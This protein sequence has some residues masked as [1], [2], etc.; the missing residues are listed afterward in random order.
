LSILVKRV[1]RDTAPDLKT[2][3]DGAVVLDAYAF[4]IMFL[5]RTLCDHRTSVELLFG[6]LGLYGIPDNDEVIVERHRL[7]AAAAKS[8]PHSAITELAD[9][10]E[11]A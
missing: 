3:K 7:R 9:L 4:E 1:E 10:F 8:L 2:P 11:S 5:I 6:F